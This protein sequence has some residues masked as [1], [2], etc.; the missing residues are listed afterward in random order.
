MTRPILGRAARAD[1]ANVSPT[2]PVRHT[3]ARFS[4]DRGD[5]FLR[6]VQR[7]VAQY[8]SDQGKSRFDD[9][10]I[11]LKGAFYA[12][13]ALLF[14]GLV[15]CEV[16]PGW[17]L[18]LFA[19]GFGTSVLLLAINV[20]HDA[21]HHAL[22]PHRRLNSL[23]QTLSFTLLGVSAYLW[24]FR[25]LKSHHVFPNVN[26]C[27][28]D[29]DETVF[30]RLTPNQPRRRHHRYQHLYA[31]IVYWFVGL[32]TVV[33]QDI[34][35]LFKKR[36]ANMTDIRHPWREYGVFVLCKL[37]YVAL[38]FVLPIAVMDRPWW[39]IVLGVLIMSAA[40]S[41]VFVTLLIGT[42]FCEEARFPNPDADGRLPH[43]WATHA[44]VTAL[45]WSPTS[46]LANFLVGGANAHAAH[47]LFPTHAHI[48][49]PAIT[50]I[51][52][53]TAAE[54]DLPYNRTTLPRMLASH[55]RFLRRMGR[56][57][58]P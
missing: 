14:Y 5:D 20:A 54:F 23:L 38:I 57:D 32:H 11:A 1:A 21:A 8:L 37:A 56:A 31:P 45:D 33:Y 3:R 16:G 41:L 46:K 47:H 34:V 28:I 44:L 58:I 17:A 36:L 35:Y 49:Y 48:H 9:G 50:R 2:S 18:V 53:E 15:L 39:H 26:G 42:H 43:G 10:S 7:R 25:H 12:A 55:F 22:T 19:V 27:D 30:F 52:R 4:R 40:M 51:I 6:V 13:A 24:Q 29:I